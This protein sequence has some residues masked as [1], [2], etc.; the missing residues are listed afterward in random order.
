M[1][2]Q[3]GR[4]EILEELGQ[5]GFAIVH[6]GRDTALDR[7]VALK[8]LR[9]VLLRDEGWVKNFRH[10]ARTI[11]QLDHPHIVSIYDIYE[12]AQRLFIVMRLVQGPSL[13]N[14]IAEQNRLP[15]DKAVSLIRGVELDGHGYLP[16]P[17]D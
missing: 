12:A 11:A 3:L 14:F 15:W 9:P 1:P 4:Y 16:G 6:R 5:G 2:E 7:E 8:E 10:E 13:E 17:G